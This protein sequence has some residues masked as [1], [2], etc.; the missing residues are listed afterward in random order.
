[1]KICKVCKIENEEEYVYCKNCGAQLEVIPPEPPVI[2]TVPEEDPVAVQPIQP[3]QPAAPAPTPSYVNYNMGSRNP[4]ESVPK[5]NYTVPVAAAPSL[6]PVNMLL[7][8]PS[9]PEI[10][11]VQ[12]VYVTPAQKAA[13]Q[14][15]MYKRNNM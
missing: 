15:D 9:N 14:Y 1:M 13:I 8:D 2:E 10:K 3:V 12:T 11:T 7:P 4:Y 5:V 6:V